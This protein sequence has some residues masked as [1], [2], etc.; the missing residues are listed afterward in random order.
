MK[1]GFLFVLI[2][3]HNVYMVFS[4][5]YGSGKE[6]LTCKDAFMQTDVQNQYLH[7][8]FREIEQRVV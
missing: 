3:K 2:Q 1:T 4:L 7:Q 8:C 6:D 5:K